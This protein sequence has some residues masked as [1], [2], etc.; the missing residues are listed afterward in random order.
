MPKGFT[1]INGKKAKKIV[2][3]WPEE[4]QR[5][6]C[7]VEFPLPFTAETLPFT[8]KEAEN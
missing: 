2:A 6:T 1:T 7:G 3:K 8:H 4:M 5:D